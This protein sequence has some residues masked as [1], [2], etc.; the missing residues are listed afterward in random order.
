MR[1][2]SPVRGVAIALGSATNEGFPGEPSLRLYIS[3]QMSK[4]DAVHHAAGVFGVQ[5]LTDGSVP[6][7]VSYTGEIDAFSHRAR[8]RPNW[9]RRS[10]IT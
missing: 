7:D 1:S 9:F 3:E 6:V 5:A 2:T 4:A 10:C 8:W